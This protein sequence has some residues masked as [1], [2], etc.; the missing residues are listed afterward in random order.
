MGNYLKKRAIRLAPL[1]ALAFLLLT[2]GPERMQRLHGW[3]RWGVFLSFIIAFLAP[4]LL[5]RRL[6]TALPT[7]N[8]A[9]L[10]GW[11]RTFWNS[12]LI[13]NLFAFVAGSVAVVIF[14]NLVPVRYM[15]LAP[16]ANLLLIVLLWRILHPR[17]RSER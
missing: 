8:M 2:I 14:H 10:E 17:E 13:L 15:I 4:M 5:T 7:K 11:A 9:A 6:E 16:C 3:A 12:M 1:I